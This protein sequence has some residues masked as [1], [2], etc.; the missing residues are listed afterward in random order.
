MLIS[1]PASY[2]IPELAAK[3]TRREEGR[4]VEKRERKEEGK[5]GEK[6]GREGGRKGERPCAL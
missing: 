2:N 4:S 5:S 3:G 1:G 6:R